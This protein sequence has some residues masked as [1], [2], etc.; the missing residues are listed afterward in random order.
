MIIGLV[1]A[2]NTFFIVQRR[3]EDTLKKLREDLNSRIAQRA[4]MRERKRIEESASI[5]K[6]DDNL[7]ELF[8]ADHEED[9]D[10]DG[11]EDVQHTSADIPGATN[12]RF[13]QLK[14]IVRDS[15]Q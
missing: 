11:G 6:E 8:G 13:E 5:T 14:G 2:F 15:M 4:E 9:E 10:E 7:D 3:F 12:S 1:F